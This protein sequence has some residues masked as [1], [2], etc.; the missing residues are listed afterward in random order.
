MMFSPKYGRKKWIFSPK[1]LSTKLDF[2]LS[3]KV[4]FSPKKGRKSGQSLKKG[5]KS[6]IFSTKKGRKSGFFHPKMVKNS[7]F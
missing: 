4:D 5:Q 6:Q 2:F 1:K 3:K 7:G